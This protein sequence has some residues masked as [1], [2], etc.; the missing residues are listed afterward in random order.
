MDAS[1]ADGGV[2]CPPP[3]PPGP[4]PKPDSALCENAGINPDF[5]LSCDPAT[6]MCVLAKAA[7][8]L[9]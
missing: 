2:V 5:A 1:A 4:E 8:S 9:K 7:P 3:P 6:M